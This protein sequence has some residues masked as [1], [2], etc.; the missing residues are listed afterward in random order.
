MKDLDVT[1]DHTISVWFKPTD[2]SFASDA[3][4]ASG[5][6]ISGVDSGGKFWGLYISGKRNNTTYQ[7]FRPSY[8]YYDGSNYKLATV[9]ITV[10]GL[11]VQKG[12]WTNLI[13]KVTDG[14]VDFRA[15]NTTH[16]R[17]KHYPNAGGAARTHDE[18]GMVSLTS[19]SN[20]PSNASGY[21]NNVRSLSSATVTMV[22][23]QLPP[24]LSDGVPK[25]N[26]LFI[27]LSTIRYSL[28]EV[29]GNGTVHQADISC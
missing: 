19:G 10:G 20:L 26:S 9:N 8:I 21:P 28:R 13:V 3:E 18:T 23:A 12:T 16:I 24:D 11:Q 6:L 4:V 2:T 15:G 22:K 1:K 29:C 25:T 17:F 27:G 14:V 5:P 7:Y